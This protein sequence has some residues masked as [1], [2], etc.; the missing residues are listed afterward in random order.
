M[1]KQELKT[2]KEL[3]AF[4]SQ[5]EAERIKNQTELNNR[6]M[7]YDSKLAQKQ[8]Q[9][10][11]LD[12]QRDEA[13]DAFFNGG[14]KLTNQKKQKWLERDQQLKDR[15][16]AL[17]DEVALIEQQK[18]DYLAGDVFDVGQYD[19]IRATERATLAG[20]LSLESRKLGFNYNS[21]VTGQGTNLLGFGPDEFQSRLTQDAMQSY[22]D[23]S[24]IEKNTANLADKLDQLLG[25]K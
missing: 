11:L 2:K 19:Q 6:L 14:G 15:Q 7:E 12:K 18:R 22:R 25:I 3:A 10:S 24:E 1:L 20:R 17:R 23:L 5:T 21:L 9:I 16:Q 8:A 4:D 13:E